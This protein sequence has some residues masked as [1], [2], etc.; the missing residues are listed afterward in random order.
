VVW[1]KKPAPSREPT[2][3]SKRI[4]ADVPEK[5]KMPRLSLGLPFALI[6]ALLSTAALSTTAWAHPGPHEDVESA[7]AALNH[8]V[9]SPDHASWLILGVTAILSVLAIKAAI[10]IATGEKSQEHR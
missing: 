10:R 8:V 3:E 7:S 5:K 6:G 1:S 2:D 4:H 9:G